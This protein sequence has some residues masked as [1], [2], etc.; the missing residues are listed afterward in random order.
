ME[1][2]AGYI[3]FALRLAGRRHLFDDAEESEAPMS[4]NNQP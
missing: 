2:Q 3:A 4:L 1:L